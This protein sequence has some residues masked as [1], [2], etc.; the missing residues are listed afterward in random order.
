MSKIPNITS[1]EK[2][3]ILGLG[4]VGLPLGIC[5]AESFGGVVGFDV[6]SSRVN[7][8]NGGNDWTGEVS[9]E[10]LVSSTLT[11]TDDPSVIAEST[12]IIVTVPTPIDDEKK[13]DLEP[14]RNACRIIG[15][16][17]GVGAIVVFESTVYP[18]VTE[19]IC[20]PLLEEY[21]GMKRGVDFKLGYSPERINPG[22]KIHTLETITKVVSAEDSATLDRVKSVYGKVI[23]AGL[24]C[25][26]TIRVAE[27]AKVIEN[28]QRDLNIALMNEL[29]MIFDLM[30]IRTDDVL[31]ASGTKWNFLPFKPGLVGGHCIGVD[32]YYLT[33]AAERLGYR[34]EVIL[35]G[36]RTNDLMGATVARKIVKLLAL[37]KKEISSAAVGILGLTFKEDVPDLRNSKVPDIVKELREFGIDPIINDPLATKEEAEKEYGFVLSPLE[38]FKDLDVVV[39]AVPHKKYRL[40]KEFISTLTRDDAI[41]ADLKSVFTPADFPDNHY[42]S[43]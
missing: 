40:S 34:P 43:L 24:H 33:S 41:I 25:A 27:A 1:D 7:A 20:G 5:L 21:S 22:D 32:P 42:W 31:A 14:L 16:H 4:Y 9:S 36:R 2:I 37:S 26:P 12:F 10:G 8:L 29:S 11:I 28:T 3:L 23:T 30:N 35:A 15:P 18:G 17:L 13:P 19:D 38:K 39:I 6:N